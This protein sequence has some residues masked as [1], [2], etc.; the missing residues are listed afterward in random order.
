MEIYVFGKIKELS[1]YLEPKEIYGILDE[2]EKLKKEIEK[3]PM[4]DIMT[5]LDKLSELWLDDEYPYRKEALKRLPSLVGFSEPMVAEGIKT[6]CSMMK[7]ENLKTRLVCDLGDDKYLDDWVYHPVFKGYIMAKPKGIVVHVSAGN[8]F[9]GGVDSLIQGIMTKNVN[10][11]KMSTVDPV[12]PVLFAKSFKENDHTG[13]LHKAMAL[14]HW[15]GG[16]ERL[17]KPLK[18]LADF[19]VVYGG[20]ETV[21]SYRKDLGLHTKLVEYGP[22]Y[23]FVVVEDRRLKR[24]GIDKIAKLIAK[25]ALMWEQSACSS[26]HVVYVEKEEN[27][28]ALFEKIAEYFD[29]W[30]DILPQG[31]VYDDE[32]VEINKVRELAKVE[33]AM[34]KSDLRVGS[35]G[36]STV[37]YQNSKEFQISCQNRTLFVKAVDNIFDVVE[38]VKPMGEYLQSVAVVAEDDT[39]K[40]LANELGSVGADRFTEAGRMSARKHGTPHDGTKGLSELVKWIS[41]ARNDVESEWDIVVPNH[42][43]DPE[44]DYF[45]F[46]DQEERDKLTLERLK[47]IV[48]YAKEH[49]P[50]FAERYKDIDEINSFDDFR[51]LPL[52]TGSDYKKYLPPAGDGLLTDNHASGYVFSSGGTTGTPKV[53]YRTFQEQWFNALKLGKGL[54]LSIFDENDVVA[55][56]LFA[57]NMWASFVSYNMALE[58]VGCRILPMGGNFDVK[59]IVNTLILFKANGF[60]TIPSLAISIAEYVDK[61]G[62]NLTIDKVVTGGEHLFSEAREY[63]RDVLKVK[64]FAS[65]GYTTNDTG[66][67]GYQCEHQSGGLHHVHEDLHYVEIL[68]ENNEPCKPGEIGRIVVTN[69]HRKLMPTIRYEVGDLGRWVERECACGRKTKVFE[70]LGRSDDVL[71]IGGGNIHPEVISKSISQVEGLSKHFQIIA[72]VENRKDTLKVIVET[73]DEKPYDKKREEMLRKIIYENSKE[74]RILHN[75]GFI[76]DVVVKIVPPNS[77]ERNPRT[78]KIR[79]IVDKRKV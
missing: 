14:I 59:D 55:N 1:S 39:A 29:Y 7:K 25:D 46:L 64:K 17:E 56:L 47:K 61:N 65:T 26:P 40:R 30:A 44:S 49:S 38:I 72:E 10:I 32:A 33:K 45:D 75:K 3:I 68:N 57:G 50:L 28:K 36:L 52:L 42:K 16:D 19:I 12:F 48:K 23:S 53:V 2:A 71:I 9:V 31:E 41:L 22:K 21:E 37:V 77:I 24:E 73:V 5:V 11:M 69:L 74:L 51:K 60:I 58:V 27:A 54:R 43:Y 76:N 67:I 13:I 62:V 66:A 8:V 6:M 78:G 70:L 79:L 34:G 18:Q 63:I 4:K 20:R 15:K 35:K